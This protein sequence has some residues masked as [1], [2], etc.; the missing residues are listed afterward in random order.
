MNSTAGKA[1][2]SNPG[3]GGPLTLERKV[4][5]FQFGEGCTAAC[6]A[7]RREIVGQMPTAFNSTRVMAVL[8]LT[9]FANIDAYFVALGR[10]HKGA[11][12]R[13][14]QKSARQGYFCKRFESA[15]Y[16]P[17]MW[18]I[19]TSKP[20]RQGGAMREPYDHSIDEMGGVPHEWTPL[21]EPACALH[22]DYYWGVFCSR[23]GHRQGEDG[24][25]TDEK[26]V[27]YI[28][29]ERQGNFARYRH[30]LGHG[31]HLADGIMY[32]LHLAVVEWI[33]AK[34]PAFG[35]D[36]LLYAGWTEIS[37]REDSRPGLT[38]WKKKT[39]FRPC[40][41][42]ENITLPRSKMLH[43]IRAMAEGRPFPQFTLANAN[44]GICIYSVA[45]HGVRDVIHLR[46]KQVKRVTLVDIDREKMEEMKKIYPQRWE[47]LVGDAFE[48]LDRLKR[49]DQTFD[50]VVLDPWIHEQ[51]R[52]L[53]RLGDL[54]DIANRYVVISLSM[55]SFFAEHGLPTKA[56][57]LGAFLKA[58]DSRVK[59]ARLMFC[60][61]FDGGMYWATICK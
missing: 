4:F 56:D 57:A 38:Q 7:R 52:N 17:D 50:V 39:L 5:D 11:G 14:A 23:L 43:E 33:L 18:E 13:H 55:K 22:H 51:T 37:G 29:L 20:A 46:D 9:Q 54:L 6:E 58:R 34:R 48:T 42:M 10:V 16:V 60:T 2:P 25:V 49:D 15:N 1:D 30:I 53:D 8:D 32:Q 61:A 21:A 41:V 47:Y 27:G 59:E 44:S 26:L 24:L 36:Y 40:Y 3:T 12:R 28:M 45:L 19:H 35:L 31:D